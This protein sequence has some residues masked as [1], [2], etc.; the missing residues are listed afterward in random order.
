MHYLGLTWDHPRGYNA[1]AAA[2]AR[3]D[4]FAL[5]WMKQPLEGFEAHPIADLCARYDLVVL[6]H[7]HVGEAVASKCLQPLEALFSA[8]EIAALQADTI[9]PCLSSYKYEGQHWALPL[10]AATQ[11]MAYR[12]DLIEGGAPVTWDEVIALSERAPVALSLAGPHAALS[13]QSI[14]TAFGEPPA[15]RDPELFVSEETG[16]AVLDVMARLASRS[17]SSV[18]ALNPIGILAHMAQSRDV[19]LCPLIY[20]YVNYASPT[21]A[22]SAP[23]AFTNAPRKAAGGRPGSTLGGTGI[24]VSI[25]CK[26]SVE[27]LNHLRWLLSEGAQS[28]FIPSRDGQPSRRS[29]WHNAA[30]NERWN[31]FYEHTA[32]TLEKAYVRPRFNG[33]IAFQ[34]RCSQLI[35]DGLAERRP[36]RAVLGDIQSAYALALAASRPEAAVA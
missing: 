13:F 15:H 35:R 30:V 34:T 11:V 8:D 32:E 10:D 16:A 31:N 27:L 22:G 17:P 20:G 28:V 29:S 21:Q 18:R 36:H 5:T 19:A 23:I 6:D 14:A 26:P 25:R 3:L 2:A 9:G 7:P 4:G 33:A 24:G 1:L 12:A